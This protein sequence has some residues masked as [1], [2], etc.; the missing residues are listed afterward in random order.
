[1]RGP[2]AL[3]WP[4]GSTVAW[5]A[6]GFISSRFFVTDTP[7]VPG[8]LITGGLV[9]LIAGGLSGIVLVWVLRSPWALRMPA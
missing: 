8:T 5:A 2:R 7:T 9:G 4:I 1:V 3:L 6:A